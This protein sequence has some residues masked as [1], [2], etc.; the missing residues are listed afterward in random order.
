MPTELEHLGDGG[1]AMEWMILR[2]EADARHQRGGVPP[3]LATEHLDGA[4]ARLAQADRELE[5]RRLPCP[6]RPDQRGHG[7]ARD[8]ERAVT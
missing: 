8:L 5:E 6:V 4:V 7:P 1:P 2:H 3:R